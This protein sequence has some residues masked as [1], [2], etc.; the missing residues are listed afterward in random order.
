MSPNDSRRQVSPDIGLANPTGNLRRGTHEICRRSEHPSI[1]LR[2]ELET[3]LLR[4][5]PEYADFKKPDVEYRHYKD[6]LSSAM[7]KK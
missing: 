1:A 2:M 3:A 5:S 4:N 7:I 6:S